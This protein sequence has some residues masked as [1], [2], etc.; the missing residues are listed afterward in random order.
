MCFYYLRMKSFSKKIGFGGASLTSMPS[1]NQAIKLL[2]LTFDLGIRHYDTAPIYGNGYSE[3]IYSKFLKGKRKEVFLVTKF[4][5]GNPSKVFP[6]IAPQLIRLNYLRR[7]LVGSANLENQINSSVLSNYNSK[8]DAKQIIHS[9]ESSLKRLGTD[10][11]NALMLHESLPNNL[12]DDS[13]YELL[14]LKEAGKVLKI[15]IACNVD[16]I[17][18]ESKSIEPIW[19]ILQYEG[20]NLK[21][22]KQVMALFPNCTHFHHSVFK[23]TI[24]GKEDNY[25]DLLFKAVEFNPYGKVIFSTRNKTRLLENLKFLND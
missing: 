3:V 16:R 1:L 21:K 11:L 8:I 22:K 15:G 18:Q 9:I 17:I 20:Y 7:Q 19:D 4:G 2:D 24:L 12:T 13:I 10:H 5:L 25:S 23:N 6:L 14:K